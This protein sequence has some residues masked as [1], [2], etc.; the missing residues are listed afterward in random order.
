MHIKKNNCLQVFS[1]L[2]KYL[3]SHVKNNKFTIKTISRKCKWL[4]SN[5]TG[6]YIKTV[7]KKISHNNFQPFKKHICQ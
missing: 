5:N 6:S 3:Y 2:L 4:H 7:N 1:K